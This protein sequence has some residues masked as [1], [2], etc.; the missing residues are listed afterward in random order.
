LQKH[1][2]AADPQAVSTLVTQMAVRGNL[3]FILAAVESTQRSTSSSSTVVGATAAAAAVAD[4]GGDDEKS[5]ST[6]QI[7]EMKQLRGAAGAAVD[8]VVVYD[9]VWKSVAAAYVKQGR[10]RDLLSLT[11][12]LKCYA[13]PIDNKTSSELIST[14]SVSVSISPDA[15]R[16]ITKSCIDL[17]TA[18]GH[19]ERAETLAKLQL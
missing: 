17:L 5:S 1:L 12:R 14:A 7:G 15:L 18:K 10:W 16:D 9:S 3:D 2:A 4:V 19:Y 13:L 8:V 11:E 6:V